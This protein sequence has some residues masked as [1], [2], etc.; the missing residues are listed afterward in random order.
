MMKPAFLS[1]LLRPLGA[2]AASVLLGAAALAQSGP[3]IKVG[4]TTAVQLQVGRDTRDGAQL[5]IDEI[6][7]KGGVLG[8][9]LVM[10]VADET[11]DPE[12]GISAIKKLMADDR[13]DVII[14]GYTSGVV[15]A[16]MPHIAQGKTIFLNIGAA[17][18]AISE[19]IRRNYDANKYVFRIGLPNSFEQ[20][21]GVTDFVTGF[22]HGELGMTRFALVGESAKWVQDLLPV[23]RKNVTAQPGLQ[24]VLMETF[25]PGT[26]NFSPLLTKVKNSGAEYMVVV[27][28][29][30]LSDVLAKQWYD[31]RLPVPY[32]GI[33]VK[34]QDADF[35]ERVGGKALSQ[36]AMKF[37]ERAP[38][39]EVTAPFLD[40]FEKRYGREP[41]YTGANAYDA[42]YAYADAARRAGVIENGALIKALETVDMPV[43]S[44]RLQLDDGHDTKAGPGLINTL[45]VQWQ[46]GGKRVLIWP[47]EAR[48]GEYI[49]PQWLQ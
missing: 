26:T 14:G 31:A 1:R 42:V 3:P 41:V 22:L 19:R 40:A 39:S 13:V 8:R 49:K 28:S 9:P 7:A 27:L 16:Q 36:I 29:H 37:L 12:K 15:L 10:V 33:D 34:S 30:A 6:N 11:E 47:K 44:G 38:L 17:S 24:V 25:D 43:S 5:A 48:T 21:R 20:A 46:A 18:P 23:L 4:I 45:F 32:G 2:L 35:F